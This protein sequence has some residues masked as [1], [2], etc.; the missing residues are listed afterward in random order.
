MSSV[1]VD[2]FILVAV[3]DATG[4]KLQHTG[5]AALHAIHAIFPP[6]AISGHIGGNKDPISVK[7]LEKGD[8]QWDPVKE[9]LGFEVNGHQHIVWLAA[10]VQSG[11]NCHGAA[12]HCK[13]TTSTPETFSV[14]CGQIHHAPTILPSAWPFFTPLNHVT[15]GNPKFICIDTKSEL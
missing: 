3:E 1:F 15:R 8:A 10:Q 14:P 13:K 12:S 7:K 4:M 2:N 6:L 9:L 11:P 5:L